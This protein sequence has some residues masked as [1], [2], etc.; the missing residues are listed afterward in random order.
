MNRV[1]SVPTIDRLLPFYHDTLAQPVE[2]GEEVFSRA[3]YDRIV[4]EKRERRLY[5]P[6]ILGTLLEIMDHGDGAR[7]D[8]SPGVYE[9]LRTWSDGADARPETLEEAQRR[10]EQLE[11]RLRELDRS[12]DRWEDLNE[13]IELA[14]QI[15]IRQKQIADP[16]D[17]GAP[18]RR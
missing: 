16:L 11:Q 15:A 3:L 5:D 1:G 4:A 10:A 2:D 9:A 14:R 6:E 18:R 13:I 17:P 8:L 12:M 7:V